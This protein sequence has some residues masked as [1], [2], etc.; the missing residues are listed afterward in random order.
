MLQ[1]PFGQRNTPTQGRSV[2]Q[3]MLIGSL[4]PNSESGE[5]RSFSIN[6]G[7]LVAEHTATY[8]IAS[9]TFMELSGNRKVLY[10]TNEKSKDATLSAL[11]I[12]QL[13]GELSPIN[14][15]Y[16]IGSAPT[17]VS[18]R[19]DKAVTANYGGGS[20]SLMFIQRD[21]SLGP[22]DWQ[23]NLATEQKSNP[24]AVV[25][26]RDGRH[27][28]VPDMA[29]DKVFHFNIH[30]SVPP[31]TISSDFLELPKGS[32]PRHLVFDNKN[33]FAYLVCEYQP[34]V[35]VLAYDANS[36]S[37]SIVQEISTQG[38]GGKGGGHIELSKDGNFLYTSHRLNGDGIVTFK[39][40]KSDGTLTYVGLTPTG[41]HPRQFAISPDN[42]YIAVA[43]RDAGTVEVYKRNTTTGMLDK[44]LL[45]IRTNKP[46]FVLWEDFNR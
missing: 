29:Q 28:Y 41:K 9:P 30:S 17:Y 46:M 13:S 40:N 36:G 44:T 24:H 33:K 25:F 6:P 37:L 15:T 31:L 4:G 5:I 43:C 7:T 3:I 14:Q 34:T 19:G 11:N 45:T 22:A 38:R 12:D 42:Q 10:V 23:I 18:V 27:L 39:V 21:G 20:I 32:G 8:D 1:N 26:S 2:Q 35:Y 16:T